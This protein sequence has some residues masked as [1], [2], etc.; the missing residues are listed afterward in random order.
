M[1]ASVFLSPNAALVT[2]MVGEQTDCIKRSRYDKRTVAEIS[3]TNSR[4]LWKTIAH[5]LVR[6][7][8]K[9]HSNIFLHS[10]VSLPSDLFP[11]QFPTLDVLIIST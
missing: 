6:H 3:Q 11:S 5:S 4:L 8:C 9:I 2:C 7:F 1:I 10:H